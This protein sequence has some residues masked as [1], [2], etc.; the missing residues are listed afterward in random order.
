MFLSATLKQGDG[1]VQ[2]KAAT[3][4]AAAGGFEANIE[5][6]REY[7]GEAADNFLI[8]GTPY[9]RG[10]ILKNA[11]DQRRA[12]GR[13]PHA[14]P[15]GRDRRARAEI[16]RR[17]HHAPRFGGVRHRRQPATPRA[18]TTR[19]RTSGRSATRS[20]AGWSRRS[21]ARSPISIFRCQRPQQLHADACSR[22]SRRLDRRAGRQARARSG[23]AGKDR[24]RFQRRGP[25]RHLRSHHPRRLPHRRADAHRRRIGRGRS[26][27]R[28]TSPIRCGP[29]SPSPISAPA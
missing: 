15:R 26:R 16:R 25:S 24:R 6:L 4:V 7:W 19:A 28:L 1:R 13:R 8:R 22:R 12:G 23:G 11:A 27:R 14:M 9:N 10:A 18:S 3:L 21:P 20:G 2:A 17:H 5:W 29:A